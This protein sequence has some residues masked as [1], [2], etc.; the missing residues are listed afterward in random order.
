MTPEWE[1]AQAPDARDAWEGLV[2]PL[3]RE[4]AGR[5]DD[6]AAEIL[7]Q[8]RLEMPDLVDEPDGWDALYTAL[9]E[10]ARA[11]AG[12]L[13][14]GDDPESLHLPP[15]TLAFVRET[16][17]RGV[18]LT[19]L[20]RVY[21]FVRSVLLADAIARLTEIAQGREAL[22]A[23]TE[24]YSAWLLAYLDR[25]QATAEETYAVERD[26]WLHSSEASS[27]DA[28]EAILSGRQS[29]E[30]LASQR[31]RHDLRLNHVALV[32]WG[33]GGERLGEVFAEL[34][35]H[36]GRGCGARPPARACHAFGMDRR[37]GAPFEDRELESLTGDARASV[38]LG[39]SQPGIEGFRRSH[40]QALEARRI[41]MLAGRRTG[42]VTRYAAVA[43]AALA[44]ADLDQARGFVTT[45]LGALAG[46]DDV[47]LR[48]AATLRVYLDE[49]LSPMRAARR[50]GIHENT[51]ANRVRQAEKLIGHPLAA[52]RLEVH[53]AL[54]L[55]PLVR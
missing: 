21:R 25:S 15:V 31:L 46:D 1:R 39:T 24:L 18:P 40:Q 8:A 54:A 38:A 47:A 13:E 14:R 34:G 26:R 12:A 45:Q 27:A 55:A 48:L 33:D 42:S 10:G 43:L 19:P 17:R 22:G 20:M 32:A 11:V 37:A 3:A 4:L 36:V 7:W 29:D 30:L 50:L 16:A 9:D 6:I 28:I 52:Q 49:N 23:A 35:G 51:V 2:A 5:S 44:T 41:A 53:V